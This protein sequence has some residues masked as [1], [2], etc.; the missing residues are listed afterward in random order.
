MSAAVDTR[1]RDVMAA[2]GRRDLDA[3][4]DV[5]DDLVCSEPSFSFLT[6]PIV[7]SDEG[8]FRWR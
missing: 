2:M 5:V 1:D 8:R 6:I 3:G 4:I 7:S